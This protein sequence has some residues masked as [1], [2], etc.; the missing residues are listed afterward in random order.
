MENP[1]AISIPYQY[2]NGEL[3][4]ENITRYIGVKCDAIRPVGVE[5]VK[6][7]N[8]SCDSVAKRVFLFRVKGDIFGTTYFTDMD[9]FWSKMSVTCYQ[10]TPLCA[11][12]MNGCLLTVN[13]CIFTY[14]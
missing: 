3:F 12:T 9:D 5:V 13:D 2:F 11:F 1:N 6:T 7:F 10:Q 8:N 4:E 14:K